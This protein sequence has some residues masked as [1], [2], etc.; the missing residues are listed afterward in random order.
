MIVTADA[1]APRVRQLQAALDAVVAP[2]PSVG[3][4]VIWAT[5]WTRMA[6]LP[7]TGGGVQVLDLH[8]AL[9]ACPG[10]GAAAQTRWRRQV[11]LLCRGASLL[12]V[13]S[14]AE[15][16][17]WSALLNDAGVA[18]P[19][20]VVP[21][22]PA[23]GD[24]TPCGPVRT[25]RI[26]GRL[27]NRALRPVL[28]AALAWAGAAGLAVEA[29]SAGA[30]D[31]L[32][33]AALLPAGTA[34]ASPGNAIL[35]DLRDD[36]A[37]ERVAAPIAV[38]EALAAG[39][40]ILTTVN[41]AL[42]QAIAA[43]GA[44]IVLSEG[45]APWSGGAAH[46]KAA[47]ALAHSLFDATAA[48][49]ALKLAI[50][51]AQAAS[52]RLSASWAR[53][54]HPPPPL[55]PGGRVLVVSQESPNLVDVRVHLPF[56]ALHDRG[57]IGGYAVLH[58]GEIVFD[59][60]GPGAAEPFDAIWVHRSME[61]EHRFLIDLLGRPFAY[62]V[63]DN[64]LATPSY[65]ESF[66]EIA[67]RTAR[68][69]L[70]SAAVVSCATHRLAG[71]LGERA[72]VR[73]ADRLVVTRNLAQ[74]RPAERSPGAPRAVIWASSDRPALTAARDAIVR[75]VRDHCLA[76]RL[77]LVCIGAS[78]PEALV[79][80]GVELEC[81]G[82]LSHDAYCE[83]LSGQAPSILVC[84]L[85]SGA[86]AETQ[87]FVDGKSDIKMIEA[88]SNGLV[89]VFSR[90]HPYQDS[91]IAGQI[92]CDN[93]YEGWLDGL[94]AAHE[95]CMAPPGAV[96]WPAARDSADLGL[97]PWADALAR[98]RLQTPVG[99]EELNWAVAEVQSRYA[100]LI[101]RE[102]FDE[103]FYLDSHEDVRLAVEAGTMA[104]G[105]DH[106]AIAGRAERRRAR[107][108]RRIRSVSDV[109]WD[110]L[111]HEISRITAANADRE[112]AIDALERRLALNRALAP[113]P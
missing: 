40:P 51:Q 39:L 47:I 83:T 99:A 37:A 48:A 85:E 32:L 76:H 109:W 73:L 97:A 19:V 110:D 71:L 29:C 53:G 30:T 90:A 49:G 56:G 72:T 20:A 16:G 52:D 63:D 12:L 80:S 42:G 5:P 34:A 84:P 113:R 24:S 2:A 59:T 112:Q 103:E 31:R 101:Q 33:A 57:V 82:L 14:A 65:R 78:P 13:G 60:A 75:A 105:Y 41:G 88:L 66:P 69:L 79:G 1:S 36:T 102:E 77:P 87:D 100:P 98:A 68:D 9:A 93:T 50:A 21:Y 28:D 44:G 17:F 95:A 23:P 38:I 45:F 18:A 3:G 92:L 108:R 70:Q 96:E 64:L 91:D 62:D 81:I 86:D 107:K 43:A 61:P 89:G 8:G 74:G 26:A 4:T 106:Y 6:P 111:L 11:A 55:G 58:G 22:A 94:A 46:H 27:D 104:C 7:T 54:G 35:L 15:H 67:R 10:W 25:L